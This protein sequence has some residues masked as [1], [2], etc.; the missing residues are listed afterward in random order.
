MLLIQIP[1]PGLCYDDCLTFPKLHARIFLALALSLCLACWHLPTCNPKTRFQMV[2]NPV[3]S[4]SFARHDLSGDA[5]FHAQT[6][7]TGKP[8]TAAASPVCAS[9]SHTYLHVTIALCVSAY[10]RLVKKILKILSDLVTSA[11][12]T[13]SVVASSHLLAFPWDHSSSGPKT[14]FH[15]CLEHFKK[16]HL[17]QSRQ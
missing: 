11:G 12:I 5:H 13:N 9:R 6:V 16:T 15:K 3:A 7:M 8:E 10:V 14:L 17:M 2:K 4:Q 1:A